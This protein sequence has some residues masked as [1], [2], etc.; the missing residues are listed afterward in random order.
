[1]VKKRLLILDINGIICFKSSNKDS[2]EYRK[3]DEESLKLPSYKIFKFNGI[4]DFIQWCLDNYDVAIWSSTTHR[5]ASEMLKLCNIDIS[6]FKFVW[7][8]D[9]TELDPEYKI[10]K[11]ITRYN[12]V[13]NLERIWS[14]PINVYRQY[15]SKNTLIIDDDHMKVRFN[16]K[17]NVFIVN[18]FYDLK[19]E[20]IVDRFNN[21]EFKNLSIK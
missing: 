11:D 14:N 21:L 8:R 6:K 10:N 19:R 20:D 5:N 1:M 18:N 13:K 12:T 15:S 4:E 9:R 16:D 17:D 2:K 7:Y 3:G